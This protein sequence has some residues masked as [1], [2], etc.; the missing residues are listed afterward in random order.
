M[1]VTDRRETIRLHFGF[2][3]SAADNADL[4]LLVLANGE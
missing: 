2:T 1:Q 3:Q 4:I